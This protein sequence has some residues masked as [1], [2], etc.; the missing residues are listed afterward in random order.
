M[1]TRRALTAFLLAV[2]VICG[3]LLYRLWMDRVPPDIVSGEALIGG[4]FELADQDGNTVTDQT[5]KG[6]LMLIYFGFT[7]CPM[8]ARPR[9]A[10][11]AP[12]STSSTWRPSAWCPCSSPSIPSATRRRC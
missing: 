12:R 1:W 10:S 5:Y 9:S 11:S 4:P 6:K 7:Y 8:P 3:M 2:L